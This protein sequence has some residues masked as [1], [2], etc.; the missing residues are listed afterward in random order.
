MYLLSKMADDKELCDFLRE[1][2]PPVVATG[3]RR[4]EVGG[5]GV[6]VV[7]LVEGAEID[8]PDKGRHLWSS[9]ECTVLIVE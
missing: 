3:D 2:R 7:N 9:I 1:T 8:L 5:E 4:R 6:K